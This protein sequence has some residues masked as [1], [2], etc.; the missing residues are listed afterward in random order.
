MQHFLLALAVLALAVLVAWESRALET[1]HAPRLV[2]DWLAR[3]GLVLLV[4]CGAMI[5]TGAFATASGPHPGDS[6]EVSRIFTIP[7]TVYV[8]VRATAVFGILY[9][10]ALAALVWRARRAPRLLVLAL[11]L[12]ALLG[13]QMAVG[14]IQY[15]EGLPWWLVLVHV[16]LA[17]ALWAWTAALTL[18][19]WRPLAWLGRETRTLRTWETPSASTTGP[20]SSAAS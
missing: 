6:S 10:L 14:E 13:V 2:P 3:A 5:L 15:R 7:G 20:S 16:S 17:A 9:A 18:A 19:F 4:A 12:L 11:G 1:G 8:H